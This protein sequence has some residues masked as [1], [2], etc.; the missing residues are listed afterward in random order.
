MI[1]GALSHDKICVEQVRLIKELNWNSAIKDLFQQDVKNHVNRSCWGAE[2]DH[3]DL[4]I[5]RCLLNHLY[6]R[7][8][9]SKHLT[10][11]IPVKG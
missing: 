1:R 5:Q 6:G 2:E 7:A 3:K 9:S 4:W 10:K 8:K 11:H